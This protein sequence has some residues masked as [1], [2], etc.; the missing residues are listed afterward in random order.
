[1]KKA[2]FIAAVPSG[3]KKLSEDNWIQNFVSEQ[4]NKTDLNE[5]LSKLSLKKLKDL[6]S[7]LVL[8]E[9]YEKAARVRDELSKRKK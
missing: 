5:D 6:L 4:K 1:M 3:E 9:N 8:Q 7:N 2:G